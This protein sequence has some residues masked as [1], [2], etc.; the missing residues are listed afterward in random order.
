MT[1]AIGAAD[2]GLEANGE[3][4][5][6]S[7]QALTKA[8]G[9]CDQQ[10]RPPPVPPYTVGEAIADS[11]AW[12]ARHRKALYEVTRRAEMD[13]LAKLGGIPVDEL[14]AKTIRRWHERLAASPPRLRSSKTGP[15]HTRE[16]PTDPEGP[17]KRRTTADKVLVIFKAALNSAFE[18]DHVANDEAWRR[19]KSF[20]DGDAARV[21]YL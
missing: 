8:R 15:K 12:Y 5:L 6:S 16:M 10:G 2:D 18:E 9:W 3:T 20:R 7:S 21:R 11:L 19:V 4:V 17:R 1:K 13:I 14:A